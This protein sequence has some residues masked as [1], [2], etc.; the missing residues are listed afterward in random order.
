MVATTARV[1]AARARAA[2]RPRT[3]AAKSRKGR[4]V[5]V[6]HRKDQEAD[7]QINNEKGWNTDY[8]DHTRI[9]VDPCNPLNS[10]SITHSEYI[11]DSAPRNLLGHHPAEYIDH[12]TLEL[13]IVTDVPAT[14]LAYLAFL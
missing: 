12:L 2:V 6:A 13:M 10:C 5:P 8:T 11:P 3:R 9:D 7:T 4:V 14:K 1:T